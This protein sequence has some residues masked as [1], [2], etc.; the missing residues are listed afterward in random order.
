MFTEKTHSVYLIDPVYP[1]IPKHSKPLN[2]SWLMITGLPLLTEASPLPPWGPL[3]PCTPLKLCWVIPILVYSLTTP[4]F[5]TQCE[6]AIYSLTPSSYKM[7]IPGGKQCSNS[8]EC[9]F[10]FSTS[11]PTSQPP[12]LA[13]YQTGPFC[14]EALVGV[15]QL[16][17]RL[18]VNSPTAMLD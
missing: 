16:S 9:H 10:P 12:N 14:W 5:E 2:L 8:C 3:H 7:Y 4:T 1:A 18:P 15:V 6:R 11:L 13:I 17:K